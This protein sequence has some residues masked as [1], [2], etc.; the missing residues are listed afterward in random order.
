MDF[1]KRDDLKFD[2]ISATS[3]EKNKMPFKEHLINCIS[4]RDELDLMPE[5]AENLKTINVPEVNNILVQ[6]S[7][8]NGRSNG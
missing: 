5:I 3:E 4:C 6:K 8:E 1:C 7:K 2:Y